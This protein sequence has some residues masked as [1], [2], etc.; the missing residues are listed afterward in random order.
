MSFKETFARYLAAAYPIIYVVTHEES[1][2]LADI[3]T[4]AREQQRPTR[5]WTMTRGWTGEDGTTVISPPKDARQAIVDL[6]AFPADT[7]GVLKDFHEHSKPA[8][9]VRLIRDALPALKNQAKPLVL[10]SPV[11][12]IPVELEK[13]VSVLDYALPV[14]DELRGIFDEIHRAAE[15]EVG[16][17]V[18]VS[19]TIA[20][21]EA[22]R[23][24]TASEAENALALAWATHRAFDDRAIQ[25]MIREKAQTLRK[26]GLVS[27]VEL[28]PA[29]VQYGGLGMLRRYIDRIAPVFHHPDRAEAFGLRPED[30]P[31]SILLV[32]PPG[33]GKSTVAK[34]IALALKIGCV[35]TDFGRLFGGIVGQSEQN[36]RKRNDLVEAMAPVVDWWDEAE[37]GLAGIKGSE[38]NPWEARVGGTMLTW[39]EE[40]RA[41]VL[42]VAT[43]NNPD[44]LPPELISRFQK[45]FF[46]DLPSL[47]ERQEI[48]AIHCR[49][50]QVALVDTELTELAG[51]TEQF[52]GR[53]LRNGVQAAVQAAFADNVPSAGS[54]TLRNLATAFSE[55]TPLARS[56]KDDVERMREWAQT[57]NIHSANSPNEPTSGG[58][59]RRL[60]GSKEHA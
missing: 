46:V 15:A 21:L 38:Q 39:Q 29:A 45:V 9:I 33:T 22:A 25:T 57:M 5:I 55:I 44:K 1:R 19:D 14:R 52:S 32:G 13:D 20:L 40:H 35:Q 47:A 58:M 16:Q 3:L 2:A 8:L 49:L 4:V 27:W 51:M 26:A 12:H 31:R 37:K 17:A 24:M 10:L 48:I 30:F 50:R 53:E 7:I 28:D 54:I 36:T 6:L 41:K 60:R 42:T 11:V 56:R 23:G 34:A 18:T 59:G 43:V